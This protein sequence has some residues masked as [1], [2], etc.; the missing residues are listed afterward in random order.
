MVYIY[1]LKLESNKYYIGKTSDSDFRFDS[2]LHLLDS[3]WITKYKPIS[4]HQLIP[5]CNN[6]D[7]DKYTLQYMTIKGIGNVRGGSY[8]QI[9]LPEEFLNLI[10]KMPKIL[11]N[12]GDENIHLM[13]TRINSVYEEI[14]TLNINIEGTKRF[15]FDDL[16]QIK[17]VAKIQNKMVKLNA[18]IQ[19]LQEIFNENENENKN[20]NK[21]NN[22]NKRF[23][24]LNELQELHNNMDEKRKEYEN[25]RREFS[26][27]S[28]EDNNLSLSY[29]KNFINNIYDKYISPKTKNINHN[30]DI[31]IKMLEIIKFNFEKKER[32]K[33]IYEE[34]YSENFVKELLSE[35]YQREIKL[36]DNQ[37]S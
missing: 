32:L 11:E 33:E 6:S 34:Y 8:Y 36:I 5:D 14:L 7:E 23:H 3:S 29:Y 4:L 1:I 30:K 19:R 21:N 20:K 12:F 9:K 26:K 2:H 13:V 15:K 31:V 22:Q 16:L 10:N 17:K 35:L 25:L 37:L 28:V 27:I 24:D 18:N